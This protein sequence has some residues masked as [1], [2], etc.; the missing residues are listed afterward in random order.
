MNRNSN[1]KL[2]YNSS[3]A[4]LYQFVSTIC[5]F[6]LPRCILAYYGSAINGLLSSILQFLSFISFM[7]LGVGAVVQ[8]SLY[9]PLAQEDMKEASKILKSASHFFRKI[10][11]LLLLYVIGLIIFYPQTQ[12]DK[13]DFLFTAMLIGIISLSY[14]AEYY[15]GIVNQLLISADQKAYIY[16][17]IQTITVIGNTVI[18]YLFIRMGMSILMVKLSTSVI[19]IFRPLILSIY[20]KK[21]YNIDKNVQLDEEPIKQ[22]WNGLAQHIAS[23]VLSSTD[24]CVLSL[25][26]T[27]ENV[28]IYSVYALITNGVKQIVSSFTTGLM[29]WFGE[30]IAKN[31]LKELNDKFGFVEWLIH[32]IVV[33]MFTNTAILIVPFVSIYTMGVNDANY[34]TPLF[35]CLLTLAAA[36]HSLRIPYNMV[37]MAAGHFK[38]TQTSAIIEVVLNIAISIVLVKK[39]G[40]IGVAI[41]T[42]ISMFYRTCYFV[43]YLSK[44]IICRSIKIYFGH[45]MVDV[46]SV[47][48]IL[49]GTKV[50]SLTELTYIGWFGMAI[51]V[52]LVSLIICI[53]INMLF[54]KRY[55]VICKRKIIERFSR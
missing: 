7:E 28:S 47:A 8:S 1:R 15:F 44:N 27:L 11:G 13:F 41:G 52:F 18:C 19:Y 31:K 34:Y 9:K 30:M 17:I 29:S 36:S 4:L 54:Y 39:Y 24:V 32:T 33:V 22:K 6:I 26:S 10:A 40:L 2:L 25:F 5:G 45:V 43:G 53:I 16:L 12:R 48:C 38:E 21:K 3:L 50:F 46:L 55:L 14:F 42:F 20:V 23:V 37:I 35:A 51:K 49:K